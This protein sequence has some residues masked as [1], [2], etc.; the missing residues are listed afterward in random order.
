MKFKTLQEGFKAPSNKEIMQTPA[1]KNMFAALEYFKQIRFKEFKV[2]T[3][4]VDEI[5]SS[6]RAYYMTLIQEKIIDNA[7]LPKGVKGF[8][9]GFNAIFAIRGIDDN[10]FDTLNSELT[11]S[12]GRDFEINIILKITSEERHMIVNNKFFRIVEEL[13]STQLDASVQII[14]NPPFS[15]YLANQNV[16]IEVTQEMIDEL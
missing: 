5:L 12:V 4:P 11:F 9:Q 2:E 6:E 1:I 14:T 3:G 16:A 10:N 8:K 7:I 13:R 15:L